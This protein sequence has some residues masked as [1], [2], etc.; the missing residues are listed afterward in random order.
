MKK[1][2]EVFETYPVK[3]GI[4]LS[5]LA[6]GCMAAAVLGLGVGVGAGGAFVLCK[7]HD[8]AGVRP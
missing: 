7:R 8:G 5:D 4:E 3:V 1:T 2:T 6:R